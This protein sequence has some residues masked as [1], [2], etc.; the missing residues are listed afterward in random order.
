MPVK[1]PTPWGKIGNTPRVLVI[2]DCLD[3]QKEA[4]RLQGCEVE[5]VG[6]LAEAVEKIESFAPK[7]LI[8]DANFPTRGFTINMQVGAIL[9]ASLYYALPVVFVTGSPCGLEVFAFQPG[10]IAHILTEYEGIGKD[11]PLAHAI[12]SSG[13]LWTLCRSEYAKSSYNAEVR[14]MLNYDVCSDSKSVKVYQ[15]AFRLLRNTNGLEELNVKIMHEAESG[16]RSAIVNG[17]LR[18]AS[19]KPKSLLF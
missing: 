10:A 8:S 5:V 16:G 19:S 6:T 18:T 2:E 13:F 15:D 7:Y 3:F 9:D 17:E 1:E 12:S 4:K 14:D 11:N